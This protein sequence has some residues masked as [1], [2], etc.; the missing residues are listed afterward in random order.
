M[1]QRRTDKKPEQTKEILGA[2]RLILTQL[3]VYRVIIKST[4]KKN[5]LVTYQRPCTAGNRE[6]REIFRKTLRRGFISLAIFL[7]VLRKVNQWGK[8]RLTV[9]DL[10]M[11]K[12]MEKMGWW[13][14][15]Y[16]CR[17]VVLLVLA[18]V[19]IS[20][21]NHGSKEYS[22]LE[23]THKDLWVQPPAPHRIAQTQTLCLR[24]LSKCFLN[25]GSLGPR[26]LLWR[27]CS[28]I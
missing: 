9:N 27:A 3:R 14:N 21:Q 2:S 17:P 8:L 24:A 28:K 12:G 4:W 25:S 19:D 23:G 22:E 6:K 26:P 18:G 20:S 10:S 5:H 16:E 1:P 11:G 15:T 7:M 13:G